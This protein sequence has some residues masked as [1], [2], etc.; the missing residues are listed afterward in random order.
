MRLTARVPATSANLGP[1]FD[2]FG[3]ALDLCNEVTIDTDAEPGVTWEGEGAD[4]L[5]DRRYRPGE[6]SDRR[7]DRARARGTARMRPCPPSRLH[8]RQPDPARARSR[9]VLGGGGRRAPRSRCALLGRRARS[10]PRHDVRVRRRARRASRQRGAAVYGGLTRRGRRRRRPRIDVD[11]GLGPAVL[12]PSASASRPT[13][14]GE[15]SRT[16][17]PL[18]DAVYNIA[19]GALVVTALATGDARSP[20]ASA[21]RDRLHEDVRLSLV[22]EVREVLRSPAS[23]AGPGVRLGIRADACSRSSRRSTTS[24]PTPARAGGSLR[25]PVRATGVEIIEG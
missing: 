16:A 21:L 4:E 5:A 20:P 25:V 19:H 14:R 24:C 9:F 8:G 7:R 11:P 3:L 17:V 22:P 10:G 13:R 6:P 15:R 1:G 18:D 23:R 12:V 2:C